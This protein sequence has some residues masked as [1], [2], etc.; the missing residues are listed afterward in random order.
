MLLSCKA[1]KKSYLGEEILRDISLLIEEREKIALIGANGAGKTTLF[2]IL[3]GEEEA[4]S[5]DLVR[6][7]ELTV[8][9]L[10]QLGDK[11]D[12]EETLSGGER[13][14][15]RLEELLKARPQLL[16]LDEPTN[17]L[18][19]ASLAWLEAQ[20]TH[21]PGAVFVISHDR[22]FL[23]RVVTR[24]I[25][26]E[27]GKTI[28]YPGNYSVYSEKKAAVR[29]AE[30]AAWKKQQA[31]I[32]HQ[33]AVIEKL[34]S[35]NR[36]KS[37]RR[38]ESRVKALEKIDRLE[39]PEELR[40]EMRLVLA[41][42]IESGKDVL[43]VSHVSKSFGDR[44]LF[45][46]VSFSLQKGEHLALIGDNGTGKTSLL[47]ILNG[48]L[49]ADAGEIRFGTNVHIGYY[50]QE[51]QTFCEDNSVFDEISDGHPEMSGTEIRNFL[52]AF[53]F[54]GDDVFRPIRVLSG[55][56]RGRLA[57]AKLMLSEANLL[58]L[59]EPT[60][61]LDIPSREILE[62]AI[63]AYPGTVFSV[64]H[65][66][67]FLNRTAERILDLTGG[68]I[69]N[70]AGNYDY[71]LGKRDELTL[72]FAGQKKKD[73]ATAP[74]K[75]EPVSGNKTSWLAAKE[76]AAKARRQANE[77][78]RIEKEIEE[79][80]TRARMIDEELLRPEVGTDPEMCRT[81][82]EEKAELT[83]RLEELLLSWEE[84]QSD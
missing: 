5:G 62:D 20:L 51:Q 17:H 84:I 8:G 46:D 44:K 34:R 29:C 80:E 58:I 32:K 82:A 78:A 59:D 33:E 74:E 31:E 18:D 41:P 22:Y 13:T 10:K 4:D 21:Y 36:E 30:L 6:K 16:L 25:E 19:L 70:Y 38:A 27:R 68:V 24:V 54:T 2:R 65:D 50:D 61:H 77:L 1:I 3:S 37:I 73:G 55:G 48:Q 67:F 9:Y 47:K 83:A 40:D 66:R 35:Y 63:R 64:S 49:S 26:I 15:A 11:E 14:R 45:S 76:E 75:A 42:K 39:K 56:E 81:L 52:A 79:A 71:Y 69:I 57:L 7:K 53:L 23:D 12:A 72:R 28:S 60:N 43:E